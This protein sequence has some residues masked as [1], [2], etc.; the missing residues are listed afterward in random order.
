MTEQRDNSGVLFRNEKKD[1]E[2][3]KWADYQGNIT[4]N[5]VPFW[6]SAWIKESKG[7]KKY[8][9]LNVKAKDAERAPAAQ[10]QP[11]KETQSQPQDDSELPF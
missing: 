5:G 3:P 7:G 11:K 2:H 6:L 9:S 10:S 1:A 8:M 4:V